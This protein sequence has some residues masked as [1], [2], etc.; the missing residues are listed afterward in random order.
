MSNLATVD[1]LRRTLIRRGHIFPTRDQQDSKC[2]LLNHGEYL[3]SLLSHDEEL[4]DFLNASGGDFWSY[5]ETHGMKREDGSHASDLGQDFDLWVDAVKFV[6]LLHGVS[7]AL[8]M[9]K[10]GGGLYGWTNKNTLDQRMK[11]VDHLVTIAQKRLRLTGVKYS[12]MAEFFADAV[13]TKVITA[14]LNRILDVRG[15]SSVH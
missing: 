12:D 9:I 11:Y 10:S 5:E 1:T 4:V 14:R 15:N 8:E 13:S 7:E 2:L 3:V 6:W